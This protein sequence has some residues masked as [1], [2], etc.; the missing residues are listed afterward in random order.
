MGQ[1]LPF[2]VVWDHLEIYFRDVQFDYSSGRHCVDLKKEYPHTLFL[3]Q[4]HR[5]LLPR[6]REIMEEQCKSIA[7]FQALELDYQVPG[8]KY[9][10]GAYN[11]GDFATHRH[12]YY[13]LYC[14]LEE[15]QM[16]LKLAVPEFTTP[17]T[18]DPECEDYHRSKVEEYAAYCEQH[19]E[20]NYLRTEQQ[21][22]EN[23]LKKLI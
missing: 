18:Y 12:R 20:C 14:R 23:T 6:V 19:N 8:G 13:V 5:S 15:D 3:N 1:L 2:A 22:H 11:L 16:L 17:S 4:K 10:W 21:R 7:I 9:S